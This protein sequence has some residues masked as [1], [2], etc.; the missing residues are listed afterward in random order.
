MGNQQ[1]EAVVMSL[2]WVRN[3]RSKRYANVGDGVLVIRA[4]LEDGVTL[5]YEF[6]V[7]EAL[8]A[9]MLDSAED[10]EQVAAEFVAAMYAKREPAPVP[11]LA[12]IPMNTPPPCDGEYLLHYKIPYLAPYVSIAEYSSGEW[13]TGKEEWA[14]PELLGWLPIPTVAEPTPAPVRSHTFPTNGWQYLLL[15]HGYQGNE[16]TLLIAQRRNDTWYVNDQEVE[17]RPEDICS[18]NGATPIT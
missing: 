11:A 10:A 4:T 1:S 15:V 3:G 16:L 18:W 17:I 8:I 6:G 12:W 14:E 2:Q 7:Y 13:F 9:G 5:S